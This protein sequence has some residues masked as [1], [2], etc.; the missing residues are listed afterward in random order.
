MRA[1]GKSGSGQRLAR[2][3]HSELDF[4]PLEKLKAFDVLSQ[5]VAAM[6]FAN[7]QNH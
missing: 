4:Q 3:V 1:Q 2:N 5:E 7:A 6:L